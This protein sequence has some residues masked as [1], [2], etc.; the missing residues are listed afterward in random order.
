MDKQGKGNKEVCVFV[1]M[2]G[3]TIEITFSRTLRS[4]TVAIQSND[5]NCSFFNMLKQQIG[6]SAYCSQVSKF[7]CW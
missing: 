6:T 4:P 7:D 3:G 2:R 5:C 1:C